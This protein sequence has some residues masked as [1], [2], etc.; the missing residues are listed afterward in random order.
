MNDP[1]LTASNGPHSCNTVMWKQEHIVFALCIS[2]IWEEYMFVLNVCDLLLLLS[3]A[4]YGM[5]SSLLPLCEQVKL[6]LECQVKCSKMEREMLYQQPI[7]HLD[8]LQ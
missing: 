1:D 3:T 8:E 7:Y 5:R 6:A 4:C 2:G